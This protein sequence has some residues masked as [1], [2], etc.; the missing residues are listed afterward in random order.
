MRRAPVSP[1]LVLGIGILAV[2]SASILVRLA[3]TEAPSLSISAWRMIIAT[4]ALAPFVLARRREELAALRR[5]ELGLALLAGFFLALH[6]ALWITSLAFTSVASSVVLVSTAPLWVALIA[7]LTLKETLSRAMLVGMLMALAGGVI[8]AASDVCLWDGSRFVCPPAQEFLSGRAFLGDLL[9]L[10]GALSVAG[11]LLIG[12]GLR[13]GVSLLSYI[14]LVYGMA[15]LALVLAVGAAGLPMFGFSPLTY[16]WMLALALVPQLIG[17]TTYN[18]ALA[19]LS[20]A[21]VSIAVLGEPVGSSILAYFL[22]EEKISLVK[23]AG[24]ALILAG[25]YLATR[26]EPG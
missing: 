2:S 23:L 1:I 8:V 5:S 18:W 19:Y 13:S 12:R 20:A 3:Q 10:G 15:A 24:M 14:F 22:L 26:S 4:V 6:V 9:A 11:Y 25:I 21:F 17:H 16:F 7:P